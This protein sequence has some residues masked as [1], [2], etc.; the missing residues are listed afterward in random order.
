MGTGL[1]S[2]EAWVYCKECSKR[3]ALRS[4]YGTIKFKYGGTTAVDMEIHG[5]VKMRCLNPKCNKWQMI[6]ILRI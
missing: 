6:N 5:T 2:G 4:N 1:M 3:L